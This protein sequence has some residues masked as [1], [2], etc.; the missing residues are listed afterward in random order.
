MRLVRHTLA[1]A[2]AATLFSSSLLR[3]DVLDQVPPDALM[4]VKVNDLQQTSQRL[5]KLARDLG[6]A[7]MF[8]PASD[9]LAAL[10]QQL[11]LQAGLN[12]A[13]DAAF[14]FV[15]PEKAG[16]GEPV[17]VLLPVQDYNAFIGNFAGARTEGGVSEIQ[18]GPG[19]DDSFASQWGEYAVVSPN[20]SL[21][22]AKPATGLK[23]T[24]A[25]AKEA[26]TKDIVVLG[27]FKAI[28]ELALPALN[29]ARG[30]VLEGVKSEL[31]ANEEMKKYGPA[32]DVAVNQA[33]NVA[34]AFLRDTDAATI[35]LSFVNDGIGVSVLSEF[36]Q[37]SYLG[38]TVSKLE[39]TTDPLLEGLPAG[40][41]LLF[42]GSK[43][44]PEVTRKVV[45]DLVAPIVP[46]LQ[47]L[48]DD[49]KP[50]VAFVDAVREFT[51]ATQGQAMG[52]MAPAQ[53]N[54]G[55]DPIMQVVY[56]LEGDAQ[57][58]ATSYR[59]M[60][61]S[62]EEL[63]KVIQ[64]GM[65]AAS[66][67]VTEDAKTVGGV[68]FTRYVTTIPEDANDPMAAQQ[69]Q[70]MKIFYGAEGATVYT[71]PVGGRLVSVMGMSDEAIQQVIDAAKAGNAPLSQLAQVQA[72]AGK[73]PK[74]RIG[75]FYANVDEILATGIQIANQFGLQA[76]VQLPPDLPPVGATVSRDG[77]ALR[78]DAHIPSPLVQSL[79]A[80]GMQLFM[81]MQ[82]GGQPGGPGGL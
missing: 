71:A 8:P 22:G 27:N 77:T 79:V 41:Y 18:F 13:G 75:V 57:K 62:Q 78:V 6:L 73:L 51:S 68:S 31:E 32:I 58:L 53:I 9:P 5:G 12:D 25:A 56:I 29:D 23:L 76:N 55:Q 16:D 82:G 48:G 40:R 81:Q 65:A 67:T 7:A 1:A 61:Q 21:V 72:V 24:P 14:V 28:R 36:T 2:A 15:S 42:G 66:T 10:K 17:Y 54:L 70:M 45:D 64:P 44:H 59:A 35:G 34:E 63:M 52:M 69:A 11:G 39:N 30:Q 33:L 4:V 74:E 47:K 37:G 19:G 20:R 43:G 80:A 49:G 3:A 60:A 38:N 50:F 46:E 26:D